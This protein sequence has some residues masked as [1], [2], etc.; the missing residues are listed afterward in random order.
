LWNPAA[1]PQV[2]GAG[3]RIAGT[4]NYCNGIIQN[5]QNIQTGPAAFNCTPTVSP[6]GN[7]VYHV[8]KHD[9]GPRLG[10]AWDP[11]GKGTTSIRT[12]Y[13]IYHEQ[14]PYS[15]V[16][17]QALNAPYLQT[18]SLT[19]TS[20]DQPLPPGS[21]L[22][23]VAAA[24]AAN[25]RAI[26][27]DFKTPYMQHWSLDFQHQFGIKTVV[28]AGYFGSKGTHMIGY[29]ELNDLPPGK[30]LTTQ[31]A[32]GNNTL[33]TPGV[34][35]SPC[36]VAGTVFTSEAILDQIRPFRGYRSLDILTP[37]FN[38]NYHALQVFAQHR[39]TGASQ[40]SLSYTWSKNLTDNQTSS[41]S[42]APQ[43]VGNLHAEYSRAVLDRRHVLSANY[44]YELPFFRAQ[45]DFV[46][47]VLGGWQVS[48][49]VSYFTGLPFNVALSSYDPAG[50]GYIPSIHAGG[51]PSLLCDPNTNAP[52]TVDQ[53]FNSAC[54][55][56]QFAA[57]TTGQSNSP[58]NAPRGSADGPPTKRFDFTMTK[59]IQL[60]EGVSLQLRAEAFNVFNHTNFRNLSVS[61]ALTNNLTCLVGSQV[62]SGIGSVTTFRDPRIVQLGAKLY[63]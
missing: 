11:F 36:Q 1:A 56:P 13:G 25:V 21:A 6:W 45:K 44:I 12:G 33:Q 23:V 2:S 30:A 48:G 22:P 28:T 18:I 39:F 63:F 20:M 57:G 54:Y 31:C 10:I 47:K 26:Q 59:N 37:R 29:T 8:S 15:S 17:L 55:T 43:D 46:G 24:A 27:T 3:N 9:F 7:A 35:T 34:V 42:A 49:I 50:I 40:A 41:V 4:G 51:R 14:I 5:A 52:H 58:G 53:W 60:H 32:S 61:R 19:L 62:C 38:S 16:E